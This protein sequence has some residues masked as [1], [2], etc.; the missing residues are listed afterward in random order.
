MVLAKASWPGTWFQASHQ[1]VSICDYV[2][3]VGYYSRTVTQE[4]VGHVVGTGDTCA[5]GAA[6]MMVATAR[7]ITTWPHPG[8]LGLFLGLIF[9][10]PFDLGAGHLLRT[11]FDLL[12]SVAALARRAAAGSAARRPARCPWGC[13]RSRCCS[14]GTPD[15]GL[16]QT[17]SRP[18]A[19]VDT[20]CSL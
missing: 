11:G 6:A 5:T 18:D 13:R 17:R 9:E 14:N 15:G 16:S 3:T 20:L 8:P 2:T 12:R 10:H 4:V 1:G 7:P 19:R